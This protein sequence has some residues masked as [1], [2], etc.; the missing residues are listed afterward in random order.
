MINL[1]QLLGIAPNATP[2]QIR[3]ALTTAAQQQSLPLDTLQKCQTWLLDTSK[4]KQYNARL[5]AEHPE[6]LENM[7][8][9]ANPPAPA[10]TEKTE[11]PTKP[12]Q[13]SGNLYELL[14]VKPNAPD[15]LI[16]DAIK[17]AAENG[18]DTDLL[19][20]ARFHLLHKERRTKYNHKIGIKSQKKL[21]WGIGTVL[22]IMVC[23]GTWK[24]INHYAE[25]EKIKAISKE[26]SFQFK[27]PQSVQFE[28]LKLVWIENQWLYLCGFVNAKNGFGAYT[29]LSPF[30]YDTTIKSLILPDSSYINI[31]SKK[32]E[33]LK[34][35]NNGEE[36]IKI[37]CQQ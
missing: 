21:Y 8:A 36:A 1:Y 7:M 13:A 26:V 2:D 16:R 25:N 12:S 30:A 22:A 27:D 4:R 15:A 29:G 35:I 19:A 14:G 28:N 33:N 24:Y 9:Q 34:I 3:K 32:V 37:I 31:P 10:E 23:I 5:F 20:Q 17:Q 6:I 11:P 18:M